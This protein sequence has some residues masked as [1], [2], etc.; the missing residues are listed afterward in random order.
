[1]DGAELRP[2][3]IRIPDP[4]LRE[5][6]SDHYA[7]SGF[8]VRPVGEQE[9]DVERPDAPDEQQGRREVGTH[10]LVWELL[11]PECHGEIVE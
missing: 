6:L 1:M 5:E 10:L 3:R 2:V 9:L 4:S 8:V 7:R 11:H